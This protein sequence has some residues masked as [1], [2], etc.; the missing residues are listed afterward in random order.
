M[1]ACHRSHGQGRPRGGRRAARARRRGARAGARP[2]RARPAPARRPSRCAGD[3]TDPASVDARGG[4]L[5]AGLQRDGAARAVVRRPEIFDRVNAR[6]SRD[7]RAGGARARARA[8]GA[9]VARSTCST[10]SAA[11]AFDESQVADY[12]KGTAYERS[13][14]RAERARA[15]R[16]GRD[17]HRAGDRQPGRAS[18]GPGRAATRLARAGAAAAADRGTQRGVPLLPP[19]GMGVASHD[20][21]WRPGQLLA[22]ERGQARRALHPLRRA[23]ELPRAGRDRRAAG[24][25][26]PRP[27]GD[28]GRRWR[29][30]LSAAGEA[31]SRLVRKP[32]LLPQG[33]LYFFLW[34]ARP[35]SAKAQ[36]ELGWA[37]TP[38]EEGLRGGWWPR[39]G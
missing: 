19:G 32:P 33:Q 11:S 20:R 14:Q 9:H 15:R 2:E 7:G 16:R 17:R 26:R 21:R 35:Q 36:R 28:A 1:R 31:L 4:G 24:R 18:T 27:A 23:H 8:R 25:P 6:G 3:V 38:L 30:A 5:R 13:K 10:P 34:D 29:R 39:L 37:P 22:A 12:P